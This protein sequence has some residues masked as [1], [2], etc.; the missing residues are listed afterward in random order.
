MKN[1]YSLYSNL[2]TFSNCVK[3]ALYF[4]NKGMI[5]N[6]NKYEVICIACISTLYDIGR[7]TDDE[8]TSIT[9]QTTGIFNKIRTKCNAIISN[10]KE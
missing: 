10:N 5:N 3:Q 1:F 8:Y 2:Y 6:V 9:S 7:L 4:S